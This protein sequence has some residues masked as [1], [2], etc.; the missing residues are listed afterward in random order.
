[1]PMTRHHFRRYRDTYGINPRILEGL[2]EEFRHQAVDQSRALGLFDEGRVSLTHPACENFV[3]GDATVLASRF[4][5]PPG[6]MQIDRETGELTE[7]LADPDATYYPVRDEFGE[8]TKER[9]YGTKFGILHARLPHPGEQVIV[10]VFHI[11]TGGNAEAVSVE[12]AVQ[13]LQGI[14]TGLTGIVYDMALRGVNREHLYDLGLHTITKVP[15]LPKGRMRQRSIGRVEA[16]LAG[17]SSEGVDLWAI[18]GAPHIPV[19]IGGKTNYV[20]LKRL[21]THRRR[22]KRKTV[23][24]YRWYNEYQIPD[25]PRVQPRLR[26]A[27]VTVR[28][29]D[30]SFSSATISRADSL[31]AIAPGEDDWERL[32]DLRNPTESVNSWVKSRLH[33]PRSR[34]PA[35]GA[36]R[37]LFALLAAALYN[38]FQATVAHAD[39]RGRLAA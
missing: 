10:D 20:A 33:G 6:T 35:V 25:D 9:V 36:P 18:N 5:S 23:R 29:D 16:R 30:P 27:N 13:R 12:R 31:H 17:A 7:R 24:P 2:L 3:A 15:Q 26:L 39:R 32:F 1:P 38:N 34:A 8:V 19:V 14:T 28:L 22:N 21:R 37:Q 4:N 11:T